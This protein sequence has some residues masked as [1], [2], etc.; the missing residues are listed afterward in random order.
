MATLQTDSNINTVQKNIED[1]DA[2]VG[3]GS[4]ANVLNNVKATSSGSD[5]ESGDMKVTN[6]D[7]RNLPKSVGSIRQFYVT[8]TTAISGS[9]SVCKVNVVLIVLLCVVAVLLLHSYFTNNQMARLHP[10]AEEN[11]K[12][13]KFFFF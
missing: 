7:V 8:F 2:I 13:F 3:T 4:D 11:G 6:Q 10:G 1:F 9:S 5:A 12:I